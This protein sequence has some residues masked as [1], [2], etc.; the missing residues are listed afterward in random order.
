VWCLFH[1]RTT[2]RCDPVLQQLPAT[3]SGAPQLQGDLMGGC[4]DPSAC[5]SCGL[6][7]QDALPEHKAD[8][9][10]RLVCHRCWLHPALWFYGRQ[11]EIYKTDKAILE[12]EW[13]KYLG[14]N[15]DQTTLFSCIPNFVHIV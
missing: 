1:D 13:K 8:P 2:T 15:S 12:N 5:A 9:Q 4:S 3:G 10:G 14:L 7:R 6:P 11:I